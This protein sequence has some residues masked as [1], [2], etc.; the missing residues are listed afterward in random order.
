MPYLHITYNQKI[1]AQACQELRES[2]AKLI[3]ILPGKSRE[4]AMIRIEPDCIMEMGDAGQPCAGVEVRLYK[5]NPQPAKAEFTQKACE[6]MEKAC[7]VPKNRTYVM[8]ME[9][10][11]WGLNGQLK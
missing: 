2:F 6:L 8:F 1:D 11:E 4:N 10:P 5:Q 3:T 7:G 9:F